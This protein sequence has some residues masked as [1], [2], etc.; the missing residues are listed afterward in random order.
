M[1]VFFYLIEFSYLN[2]FIK[3]IQVRNNRVS[4]CFMSSFHSNFL[5]HIYFGLGD[6]ATANLHCDVSSAFIYLYD[7]GS[8]GFLLFISPLYMYILYMIVG[9][10]RSSKVDFLILIFVLIIA[11]LNLYQKPDFF[12][13]VYIILYLCLRN[14]RTKS[15]KNEK[16]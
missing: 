7:Y 9:N 12:S 8:V 3:W 16:A 15:L 11:L 10:N 13:P 4:S 6:G 5:N 1:S 2:E 14:V